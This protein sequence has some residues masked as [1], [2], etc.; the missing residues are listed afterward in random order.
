MLIARAPTDKVT[1]HY[2]G[3][4]IDGKVFDSSRDRYTPFLC[5]VLSILLIHSLQRRAV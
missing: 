3:T 4:L 1:I 5:A 2:V